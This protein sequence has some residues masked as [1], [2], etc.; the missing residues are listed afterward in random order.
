[1]SPDEDPTAAEER[2]SEAAED[3]TAAAEG[4]VTAERPR[5]PAAPDDA[6]EPSDAELRAAWEEQLRNITAIDV[7]IQTAVSLINLA[8]RRLGIAPGTEGE[9][10]LAQV[11]DAIDAVR[12]LL[13]VLERGEPA[14]A[15]APLRDAVSALQMEYAKLVSAPAGA[16]PEPPAAAGAPEDPSDGPG[17]AQASGRLWV[18]GT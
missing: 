15:L 1:M 10:D 11:R 2:G 17:P 18:P 8:G 14:E 7:I 9:R 13:P 4:D 16:K 12:G 3:P 6:A 5:E